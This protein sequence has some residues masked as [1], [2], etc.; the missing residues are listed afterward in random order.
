MVLEGNKIRREYNTM[1]LAG[2]LIA[3]AAI[4]A[5]VN[6]ASAEQAHAASAGGPMELSNAQLDSVV[7]AGARV[8]VD[9]TGDAIVS[10]SFFL[11]NL[12]GVF[13][14]ARVEAN[15]T[16]FGPATIIISAESDTF[17]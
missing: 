6:V 5:L 11:D 3:G 1:K 4:L 15:I 17:D 12:P 13:S 8:S 7:A 2:S 9:L 10:G 16:P 14:V